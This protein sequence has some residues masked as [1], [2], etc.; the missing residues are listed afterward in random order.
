M[1]EKQKDNRPGHT[2]DYSFHVTYK[3]DEIPMLAKEIVDGT[4][5]EVHLS[6]FTYWIQQKE[7][8]Y[9]EAKKYIRELGLDQVSLCKAQTH[10]SF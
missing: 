9:K 8:N 3:P 7:E 6:L 5:A 10:H 1:E 2:R 4:I